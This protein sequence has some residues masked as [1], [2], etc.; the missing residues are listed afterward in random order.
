VVAHEAVIALR[1][2]RDAIH[3]VPRGRDRSQLGEAT[4]ERRTRVRRHL[5]IA[6]DV[7]LVLNV[8]RQ[9]VQK[10][11]PLLIRAFS[12]MAE[13]VPRAVL[14]QAG[15]TGAT[16]DEASAL[17]ARAG[18]EDRVRMLGRRPD[19]PDLLAAADLFVSSSLWEGQGGAVLEALAMGLPVVA[20]DDEA[21]A[22]S[23]GGTGVL[24]PRGDVD[25]LADAIHQALTDRES[26][27]L[28]GRRAQRRFDDTFE[29][30]RVAEAMAGMY[31]ETAAAR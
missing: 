12:L 11:L 4:D 19:V 31:R 25:G 6:P 23:L 14:L 2:P 24:V 22:E 28:L 1:I 20:F 5:G 26:S 10:G 7:P 18:L 16:T 3:V 29:I 8:A 21:V 15:R 13:R 30:S 9:Q 17:V 27:R